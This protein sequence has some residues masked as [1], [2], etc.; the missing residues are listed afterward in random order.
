MIN[1]LTSD[2]QVTHSRL[3]IADICDEKPSKPVL[4]Q[5]V[6]DWA[7]AEKKRVDAV[8]AYNERVKYV[9]RELREHGTPF[10]TGLSRYSAL[11]EHDREVT[12]LTAKMLAA[13]LPLIEQPT[14]EGSKT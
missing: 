4:P 10:P 6:I 14:I 9:N 8:A 2:D 12:A 1:V 3:Q 7:L 13:V 11:C 5:A